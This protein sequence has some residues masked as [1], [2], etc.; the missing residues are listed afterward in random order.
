[1][2]YG[3]KFLNEATKLIG[4][5]KYGYDQTDKK[6][7][8]CNI[9]LSNVVKENEIEDNLIGLDKSFIIAKKEFDDKLKEFIAWLLGNNYPDISEKDII[10]GSELY[11][12]NFHI[13]N[14]KIDSLKIPQGK[15]YE[16]DFC[17]SSK[18]TTAKKVFDAAGFTMYIDENLKLQRII[19]TDI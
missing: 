5:N 12:I 7:N 17:F 13:G 19:C 16:Y 1:M 4:K 14:V 2:I 9:S 10:K 15:Y 11:D 8:G 6:I 18:S 3:N